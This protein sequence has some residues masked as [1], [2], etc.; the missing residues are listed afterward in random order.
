MQTKSKIQLIKEAF[1]IK[2]SFRKGLVTLMDK[3]LIEDSVLS[4]DGTKIRDHKNGYFVVET[5]YS[6]IEEAM[7]E[8]DLGNSVRIIENQIF[9]VGKTYDKLSSIKD[10]DHKIIDISTGMMIKNEAE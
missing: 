6:S 1:E 3:Y 7:K 5:E 9:Q 8:F 10:K 4:F 2:E